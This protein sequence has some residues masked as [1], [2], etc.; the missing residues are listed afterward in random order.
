[1]FVSCNFLLYLFF[2]YLFLIDIDIGMI[3]VNKVD[4]IQQVRSSQTAIPVN[5]QEPAAC[6]RLSARYSICSLDV[7]IAG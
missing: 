2:P 4:N 3:S 1:M 5:F 6:V 7:Y